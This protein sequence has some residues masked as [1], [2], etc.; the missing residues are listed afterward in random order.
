MEKPFRVGI[1]GTGFGRLVQGPGFREHPEFELVGIASAR[2]ERA[3][4][5]ARELGVAYATDN[6]KK[7][8]DE[9]E[10]DL[11][12]VITPPVQHHPMGMRVLE[13][14]RDLLL[15]KP[16]AMNAGQAGQLLRAAQAHGRVHALNHEFRWVPARAAMQARAAS[17]AMGR[18]L[19]VELRGLFDFYNGTMPRP[20]GWLC[21]ASMG[22]G[23]LGALGSHYVDFVRFV[24]GE[25]TA[26]TARTV[27]Q[28]P[29]RKDA[30]GVDRA[31]TADDGFT[32]MLELES[33]ALGLIECSAALSGRRETVE[34]HGEKESLILENDQLKIVRPGGQPEP[35]AIPPELEIRRHSADAR[36]DPFYAFLDA[37]APRLRDRKPFTPSLVDGLR[38][39]QVLDGARLSSRTGSRVELAGEAA[40]A[41]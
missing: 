15:E 29:S 37:L 3:E 18:I 30:A 22:G 12:S 4:D 40:G 6:W 7:M 38:V 25:I 36:L 27:T 14:G 20:W 17:G 34:I 33:G 9:L 1:I 23:I 21:D 8:L 19:R 28:V 32:L 24:A 39:Q 26:V 16:T 5:A 31:C 10:M 41:R 11:V 2:R 13:S 35:C